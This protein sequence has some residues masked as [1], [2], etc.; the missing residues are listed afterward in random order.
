MDTEWS[1][2]KPTRGWA[3]CVRAGGGGYLVLT[4]EWQVQENLE[5]LSISGH[6]NQLGNATIERLGG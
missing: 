1:I 5:W 6:N 2:S 3:S 4:K